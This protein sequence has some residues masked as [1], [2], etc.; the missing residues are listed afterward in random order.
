MCKINYAQP[1]LNR[2][3]RGER[4]EEGCF[5]W[6]CVFKL[7]KGNVYSQLRKLCFSSCRCWARWTSLNIVS[8]LKRH[9]YPLFSHGLKLLLLLA[10]PWNKDQYSL[11]SSFHKFLFQASFRQYNHSPDMLKSKINLGLSIN[12]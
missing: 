4:E 6:V 1:S 10:P 8:G 11:P 5:S 2:L 12:S 3:V 7:P 9:L